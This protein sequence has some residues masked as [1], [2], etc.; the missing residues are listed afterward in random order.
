MKRTMTF[1]AALA[2]GCFLILAS[3]PARCAE[4]T[5]E[6]TIRS[7]DNLH[8]IAGYYYGNPRQWKRIWKSN[9]KQLAGPDQLVPGKVLRIDGESDDGSL[10]TYDDFRARVDGK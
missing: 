5:I 2:A 10:G 9:H 4:R 7:G 1:A 3:A 8:L 6:H